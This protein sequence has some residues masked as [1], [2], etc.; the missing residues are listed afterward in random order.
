MDVGTVEATIRMRDEA[1]SVL[2]QVSAHTSAFGKQLEGLKPQTESAVSGFTSM[3]ETLANL[4]EHPTETLEK[5]AEGIG[6]DLTSALGGAESAL[7]GLSVGL[8]VVGGAA[9][10]TGVAIF[11]LTERA[12]AMGAAMERGSII[13]GIAAEQFSALKFATEVTGG[14]VDTLTNASFMLQKRLGEAGGTGDKAREALEKLGISSKQFAELPVDRQILAISDGFRGLGEDVN[15]ASIAFDLFGRQ[16]REMLPT[17]LQP[18]GELAQKAKDLGL[19]WSEQDVKA[20]HEFEVQTNILHAELGKLA[21]D[22]GKNFLPVF[23]EMAKSLESFFDHGRTRASG[24][25]LDPKAAQI[26]KDWG[27]AVKKDA[28]AEVDLRAAT[29]ELG[30]TFNGMKLHVEDTTEAVVEQIAALDGYTPRVRAHADAMAALNRM[31]EKTVATLPDMTAEQE[32][33]NQTIQDA[34]DYLDPL[35]ADFEVFGGVT[36]PDVTASLRTE[37]RSWLEIFNTSF[38][39]LNRIFQSAFEGGGGLA[40]AIASYATEVG[41]KLLNMIPVIGPYISQFAGAIVAGLKKVFGNFSGPSEQELQGRDVEKQ[42][43]AA[44]GGWQ[45]IQKALLATGMT[46]DQVNAKI[47]ALWAAELQGGDAVKRQI[48][49]INAILNDQ[50]QDA[51][52]LDAAIQRYGFSIEELGPAMKKQRLDEQAQQLLNDWR[53][54]VGSG[55]DIVTVDE[56]MAKSINDYLATA[57]KTGVEVPAAMKPILEKMIEEGDLYD[58]NG[59]KITDLAQLGVSFSESMTEG[60][61]RVVNKLQELLDKLGLVPAKI[62]AI[63]P[64]DIPVGGKGDS[65]AGEGGGGVGI[66]MAAG[67]DFYVTKPTKFIA[68]EAGPEFA[69]FSGAYRQREGSATAATLNMIAARLAFIDTLPDTLTRA[70]TVA[71]AQHG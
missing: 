71:L 31:F 53:L 35:I 55:M 64:I 54:L 63:P 8:G 34:M 45:G 47:Q 18:M 68:G 39:G 10:A 1:S 57:K 50:K 59:N 41:A 13:S 49:E 44:M 69:S 58:E 51:A 3:K 27:E 61:T 21:T 12:A 11:E 15:K 52:D 36:L 9:A 6:E 48:D 70:F 25:F 37:S 32:Q 14:S 4:W 20:A 46:A 19:T 42:F 56:H 65:G 22:I 23:V 29:E 5:F 16:G 17:L 28:D 24:T 43:E 33:A 66:P 2:Q 40:G 7:G 30:A 62:K 67:G 60:F 38:S 26:A